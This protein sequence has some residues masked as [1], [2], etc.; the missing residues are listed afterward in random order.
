MNSKGKRMGL[1]LCLTVIMTLAAAAGLFTL[2]LAWSGQEVRPKS[3]SPRQGDRQLQ[4]ETEEDRA[5][6]EKL[7]AITD[8]VLHTYYFGFDRDR[9]EEKVLRAL[10]AS[11]GDPYSSYLTPAESQDLMDG[12]NG[13]F[14]G[15]GLH[16]EENGDEFIISA[17]LPGSPAEAAGLAQG[18]I[19]VAVEEKAPS[20]LRALIESIRGPEGSVM[21]IRV[22][23]GDQEKNVTVVRGKIPTSSVDNRTLDDDISYIHIRS[24]GASTASDVEEALSAAVKRKAPGVVLDLRANPG[25][26]F[27]QGLKTADLFLGN[28]RISYS[29]DKQEKRT[30]Y[31]SDTKKYDIKTVVLV[32]HA[33]AS[34]AEMVA[35]ALQAN[36]RALLIGEPTYGKGVMQDFLPLGDGSFLNLT[37]G[38]FFL[39]NGGK[40]DGIGIRPDLAIEPGPDGSGQGGGQDPALARARQEIME[41]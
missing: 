6:K 20:D 3:L 27:E 18:D 26:L 30:D 5:Y 11:L 38:E 4:G 25:G 32:D 33:T 41:N 21:H 10:V 31:P 39:P 37:V 7:D 13:T 22:Q 14:T 9:Y 17:I 2:Y 28:S 12:M 16:V 36:Q 23:R 24:F 34:T 40:V 15:V 8:A 19:I 35:G 1:L 29:L